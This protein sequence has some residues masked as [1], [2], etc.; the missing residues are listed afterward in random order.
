MSSPFCL[1]QSS[2]HAHYL[3]NEMGFSELT[4]NMSYRSSKISRPNGSVITAWQ[5]STPPRASQDA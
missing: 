1:F 2:N 4:C 3:S 5:E